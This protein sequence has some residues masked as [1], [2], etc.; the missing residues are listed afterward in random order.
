MGMYTLS[1]MVGGELVLGIRPWSP[2][3]PIQR[4]QLCVRS[5]LAQNLAV[6]AF[7]KIAPGMHN[8][9]CVWANALPAATLAFTCMRFETLYY[10]TCCSSMGTIAA[11]ESQPAP[12][13]F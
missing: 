9:L 6:F 5:R 3:P 1:D 8:C 13:I 12:R 7:C 10:R 4:L 11:D 2:A